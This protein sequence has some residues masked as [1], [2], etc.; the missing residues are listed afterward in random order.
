AKRMEWHGYA[1]STP[2]ADRDAVRVFFGK[3]G[4]FAFSHEGK[5]RWKARVGDDT[6]G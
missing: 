2:V 3:S 1:S 4:L 5:P 6:H